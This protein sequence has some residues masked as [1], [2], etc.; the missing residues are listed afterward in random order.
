MMDQLSSA[1]QEVAKKAAEAD[2]DMMMASMVRAA[3]PP[4]QLPV[5]CF[6]Q[7][8]KYLLCFR[9]LTTPRRQRTMHAKLKVPLRWS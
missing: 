2:Q 5:F 8:C 3:P 4:E 9:L 7:A 1:E 6:L